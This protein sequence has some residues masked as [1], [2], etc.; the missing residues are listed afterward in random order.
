MNEAIRAGL[1]LEVLA[2]TLPPFSIDAGHLFR[3]RS[4]FDYD[5]VEDVLNSVMNV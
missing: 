4:G 3:L 5:K 2:E 1:D